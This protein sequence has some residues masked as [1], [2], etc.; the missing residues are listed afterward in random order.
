MHIDS[1]REWKRASELGKVLKQDIV[2][3][4]DSCP[5]C[6]VS[7][8]HRRKDIGR[9]VCNECHKKSSANALERHPMWR[10]GRHLRK[11]GYVDITIGRDDPYAPMITKSG[12]LLEHRLVMAKHLGRCLQPWEIVHHRNGH[13]ADNGIENLELVGAQSE[14]LVV[15]AQNREIRLLHMQVRALHERIVT[16]ENQL[17]HGNSE[18]NSGDEPDK[19]VETR[20]SESQKGLWYSPC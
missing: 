5:Q 16:L 7:L 18:L 9:R 3:Y 4:K 12:R 8:W 15:E 14:H 17:Q 2:F 6:G 10:G 13:R 1:T 11:D 20:G 19:C